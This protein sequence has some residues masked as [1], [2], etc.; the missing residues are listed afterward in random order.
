MF[1]LL[2]LYGHMEKPIAVDASASGSLPRKWV[3]NEVLCVKCLEQSKH[4]SFPPF[5]LP[6]FPFSPFLALS[7]CFT[8]VAGF[9]SASDCKVYPLPW[10]PHRGVSHPDI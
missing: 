9:F 1:C 10:P 4:S 6:S 8:D 5:L 2:L 7:L 3:I